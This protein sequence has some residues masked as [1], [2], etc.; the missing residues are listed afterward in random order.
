VADKL[1]QDTAFSALLRE[2]ERKLG[3]LSHPSVSKL[4]GL[5]EHLG[6]G[7]D[8]IFLL[9]SHCIARAAEHNTRPTM[10]QIEQEGYAW[11]RM[12]LLDL[13]SANDYLIKYA[14]RRSQTARYMRVLRLEQRRP[15]PTEERYLLSW[16]EM[17]FPAE[18]LAAAFDKTVFRCGEFKWA[19]CNGIL[20]KWHEKGIHTAA[21]AAAEGS[22]S[23]KK[24]PDDRNAW[25]E[26]Y[27]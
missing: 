3:P 14:G 22:K 10:R 15:S 8:V 2:V 18:T 19:Y 9:A 27:L 6:L 13:Q 23:E 24:K 17:G 7:A 21:E 20:K 16:A 1:E 25:M 11:A 12:G 26:K 5:Y 4:L